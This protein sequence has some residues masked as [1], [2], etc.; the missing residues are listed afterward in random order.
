MPEDRAPARGG[1]RLAD[2]AWHAAFQSR[3]G[4]AEWL[5]PYTATCWIRSARQGRRVDVIC[6]GF[7][8]DCL[9]T[10]EE[11]AIEGSAAFR[12]AAGGGEFHYFRA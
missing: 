5:K 12:A 10:L 3:F 4:R 1:A 9:E 7:A 6:P 8:A 11:I 2:G